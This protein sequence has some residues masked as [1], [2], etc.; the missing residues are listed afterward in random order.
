LGKA[1]S[2]FLEEFPFTTAGFIVQHFGKSKHTI[3]EILQWELGPWR[4]FRMLVPH[5]LSKAQKADRTAMAN[6]LLSVLHSQVDYSFSRIVTED[7]FWFL[8]LSSFDYMFSASRDE[9]IPREKA[10][11]W[12]QK[13][14]LAIFFGGM[15]LIISNALPS[16]A[17]FSQKCFIHDII[18]DIVEAIRQIFHG[19]HQREFS[20]TSSILCVTMVA[21]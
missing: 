9:V 7:E 20:C 19:F 12:S 13:V 21:R 8:F 15:S 18:P 3:K 2:D 1:L 6:D 16:G 4:F 17:Q 14:I 11:I 5:S 10:T